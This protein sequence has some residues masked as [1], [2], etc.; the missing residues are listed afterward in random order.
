M[1]SAET[2]FLLCLAALSLSFAGFSAVVVTLRGALGGEISDRHLRLVR[3]Y[4]EG[5]LLVTALALVPA[6]LNLL[7]ISDSLIWPVSSAAAASIF[8]VLL[9]SQFRRRRAVEGGR[10]P[11][12]VVIIYAVS[13]VAVV[14]LWLNAAGIPFPPSV[15]PYAVALTWALC[16]FGFIFVRT[17]DIFLSRAQT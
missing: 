9:L 15:G 7:P 10:F 16:V 8:T 1:T 2:D 6:L 3:L 13:L 12:W 14:G 11:P 17:I 4:I 5:G